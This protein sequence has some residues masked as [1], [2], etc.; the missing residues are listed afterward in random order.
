MAQSLWPK[1]RRAHQLTLRLRFTELVTP[2]LAKSGVVEQPFPIGVKILEPKSEEGIAHEEILE[3]LTR[4]CV[5]SPEKGEAVLHTLIR[6]K[7]VKTGVKNIVYIKIC[8]RIAINRMA[9]MWAY[10]Q[11]ENALMCL[12]AELIET[13]DR[14]IFGFVSKPDVIIVPGHLQYD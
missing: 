2:G 8:D 13:A 12:N 14:K 3:K 5:F 9:I 7:Q 10:Q 1:E 4:G 11:N 6:K